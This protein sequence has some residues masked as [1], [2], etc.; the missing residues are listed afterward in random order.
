M[1]KREMENMKKGGS[2]VVLKIIVSALI[3]IIAAGSGCGSRPAERENISITLDKEWRIF[4]G[5]RLTAGG[6]EISAKGF[7]AENWIQA[8]VPTTVM[9]ALTARGEYEN[10]YMGRN[11]ESIPTERFQTAWWFRKEFDL[12]QERVG[13]RTVLRFD[14]IN[15]SANI[16]LNGSLMAKK[17]TLR[18]SY[19]C[20]SLDVSGVV[21]ESDNVLAVEV[22]PPRPGDLTIGFV[23]WNPRPP[24]NNMGLWREVTL[25]CTGPVS[26]VR[27]VVESE[28]DESYQ[29]ADLTIRTKLVNRTG[30][31]RSGFVRGEIEGVRF[32]K[33]YTLKPGEQRDFWIDPADVPGLHIEN[34]RLWWPHNL[35]TPHLHTLNLRVETGGILSDRKEVRFGIRE[36]EDYINEIGHR[37][38]KVNGKKILVKGAGWVDDLFLAD[39][40][41][42]VKAQMEYVKHMNL[43]C[44]RLEG[45]WGSSHYLYDLADELGIL[46]MPGWSCQWEWEGYLGKEVDEFGGIK[47]EEDMDLAVNYLRDQVLYLRRHPSIF[48]W[49]LGSDL[50][51]RPELEKRYLNDLAVIDPTRPPLSACDLWTSEVSGPTAVKMNGPYDYVPPVYWWEDTTYGGAYGFNSETG[52]GP[53]PPRLSSVKKMIPEEDL[54]PIGDMWEYHCGRKEFDNMDRYIEALN[55]RYGKPRDLDTFLYRSQL[56][57]YEAVRAMFEAFCAKQHTATGVIQWMLNSAWPETYWQLYDW[58]LNPT[59]AFYGTKKGCC[60]LNIVYDYD[61]GKAVVCNTTLL[62]HENL[63][64]DITLFDIDS[65][66]VFRKSADAA[67]DANS[68]RVITDIELPD[69]ND[70]GVYFLDMRLIDEEEKEAG[71]SFYWLS[72]EKDGMAYDKSS[73]YITPMNSFAD[74]TELNNLPPVEVELSVSGKGDVILENKSES[75]AFGLELLLVNN[76][77]EEPVLP[78]FWDDNYISL[79]PGETRILSYEAENAADTAIR[80]RGWNVEKKEIALH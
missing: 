20:F 13:G 19:R 3:V 12:P 15:F 52:P 60:P 53:Q 32:K 70:S 1:L 16:W 63:R 65:R 43:N 18:G 42:K 66:E 17:D 72:T 76:T 26:L 2:K 38:Y 14:G 44:V 78:V 79:L 36:F 77:T 29:N 8:T 51:P 46:L 71:R 21:K 69:K 55:N 30:Q 27:P 25:V 39:T 59:G 11:L 56:A 57:S 35:G 73:W 54:W 33:E 23:D 68:S 75:I 31:P 58:F 5:D 22:F 41:E 7:A 74:Y 50:L 9:G 34:A 28:L 24:D 6:K 40:R 10:W 37:G 67:I 48:T 49:V 61:T 80:I 4:S 47:T 45:F 64:A 62:T